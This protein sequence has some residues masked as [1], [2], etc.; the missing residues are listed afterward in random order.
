M[1]TEAASAL[2]LLPPLREALAAGAREPELVGLLEWPQAAAAAAASETEIAIAI[3]AR[4]RDVLTE[5]TP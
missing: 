3:A 1:V 5:S 4:L 2:V